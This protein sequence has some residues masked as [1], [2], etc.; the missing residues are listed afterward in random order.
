MVH[1]SFAPRVHVWAVLR[2]LRHVY[3]L[4]RVGGHGAVHWRCVCMSAVA[5]LERQRTLR[6][7]AAS[8]AEALN[9]A[10]IGNGAT[11]LGSF[12]FDAYPDSDKKSIDQRIANATEATSKAVVGMG[13]N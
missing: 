11:A 4:K 10:T 2:M 3:N 6:A 12:K 5:V 8:A 7:A 9:A 1:P 13:F